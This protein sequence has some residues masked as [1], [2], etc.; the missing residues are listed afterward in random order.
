MNEPRKSDNGGSRCGLDRRRDTGTTVMGVAC[1]RHDQWDRLLEISSNHA[2]FE[3]T[4]EKWKA[5]AEENLVS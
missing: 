3:N 5:V 2:E 1:Y 4:Y